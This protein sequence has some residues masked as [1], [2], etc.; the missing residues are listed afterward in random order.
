MG[1][2]RSTIALQQRGRGWPDLSVRVERNRSRNDASV[3]VE[4]DGP[5]SPV[6]FEFERGAWLARTREPFARCVSRL[7]HQVL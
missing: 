2:R 3:R 6:R 1:A 4:R 7:Q 5:S